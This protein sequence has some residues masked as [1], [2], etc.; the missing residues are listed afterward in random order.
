M[1]GAAFGHGHGH[2]SLSLA[3]G[4]SPTSPGQSSP[5]SFEV[6]D[7]NNPAQSAHWQLHGQTSP[8]STSQ[9]PRA[10]APLQKRR[11]VTR[12][13]DECV[14]SP[15]AAPTSG[16]K[17]LIRFY[18]DARKLN[19]MARFPVRTVRS[20]V[21]VGLANTHPALADGLIVLL[22]YNLQIARM[23]SPLIEEEI[24]RRNTSKLWRLESNEQKHSYGQSCQMWI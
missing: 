7:D 16:W 2:G 11:R 3:M 12:A 19:V 15:D 23:T 10:P 17:T 1:A 18:R 13:C 14:C 9:P 22:T 8:N 6:D 20:T 24:L 4:P 21:M 5:E